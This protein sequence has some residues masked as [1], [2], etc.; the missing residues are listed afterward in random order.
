MKVA[1]ARTKAHSCVCSVIKCSRCESNLRRI[2]MAIFWRES[3]QF[4]SVQSIM[5]LTC[6]CWMSMIGLS[7]LF[8]YCSTLF[9][10]VNLIINSSLSLCLSVFLGCPWF[11][12]E[13]GC[14]FPRPFDDPPSSSISAVL[15]SLS[16]FISSVFRSWWAYHI[17]A[18]NFCKSLL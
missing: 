9:N 14:T 12:G 2:V 8:S 10:G 15:M 18:S 1:C 7:H 6:S 4:S 11:M 13:G 16:S 3:A 17:L 5:G